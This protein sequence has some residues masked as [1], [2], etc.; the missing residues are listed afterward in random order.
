MYE[1]REAR[2]RRMSR[3][4]SGRR[5]IWRSMESSC[6]RLLRLSYV[7]FIET[8]ARPSDYQRSYHRLGDRHVP[9]EANL[10]GH[11]AV[12][13]PIVAVGGVVAVSPGPQRA[14]PQQPV[15]AH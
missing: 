12:A 13:I 8:G 6:D 4:L 1:L 5:L 3:A 15:L 2:Q 10:C 14:E 7:A 11:R 9:L